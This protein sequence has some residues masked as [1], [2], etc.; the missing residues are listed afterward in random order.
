SYVWLNIKILKRQL[1]SIKTSLPNWLQHT[2][3]ALRLKFREIT[4]KPIKGILITHGHGDHFG[5]IQAFLDEG[6]NPQVWGR[7]GA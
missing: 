5:G 7:S 4:N 3:K 1:T 6:S 2:S